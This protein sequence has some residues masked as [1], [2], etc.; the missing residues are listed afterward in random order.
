MQ[1]PIGNKRPDGSM[2]LEST[3]IIW[4]YQKSRQLKFVENS[5]TNSNKNLQQD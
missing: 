4:N 5:K 3:G 1:K 2:L